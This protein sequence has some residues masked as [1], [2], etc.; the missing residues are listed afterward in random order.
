MLDTPYDDA[1]LASKLVQ[2]KSD[3]L[4]YVGDAGWH[5]ILSDARLSLMYKKSSHK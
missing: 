2:F 5:L 3:L 4:E 1:C